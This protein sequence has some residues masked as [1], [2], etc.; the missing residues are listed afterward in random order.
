MK[1][2]NLTM[3]S[4]ACL[5]IILWGCGNT[6]APVEN[7]GNV[8]ITAEVTSSENTDPAAEST[9][10][11][12]S[13]ADE[14]TTQAGT[15]SKTEDSSATGTT[16][17]NSNIDK[18]TDNEDHDDDE[19]VLPQSAEEL[20]A[21]MS[22]REK[23]C[24]MFIV[25]PEQLTGYGCVTYA[26]STV[27]QSFMDMPVGGVILFAQNLTSQDQTAQ[28]IAD[29][30][31]YSQESCGV[32]IFTAVDEEGGTVAR[33]A[34][35][36]GTTS[37]YNMEY[38]G[39]LNDTDLAYDVGSTIGSDLSGL[40]F[41][42]DFAPVA[43]VNLN[44]G[45][46]LGSRIFSSDPYV[47]SDMTAAVVRGLQD[48]GV[49]ATLKHFPGLGAAD[50][51][52]HYDNYVHIYRTLDELR[53]AE[54]VAFSGG[55]EAGAD[56]VMVGHQKVSGVGDD[57]PADLSYTVVTTLLREELGFQGLAVTDAQQMNTIAGVY[58]SGDAAVRS[59][60]AG[61]DIILMPADLWSAVDAI[62]TAVEDGRIS[63]ER[64]DESVARILM[65][66]AE[67]GLI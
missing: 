3:L 51:N 54:F 4:A 52:T 66:K 27:R 24:Q 57:L 23:V 43:D 50:G 21:G 64:I 31:S 59:V 49:C 6:V 14:N 13:G 9:S 2:L 1:K 20:M 12:S 44:S 18:N 58:G 38:Y 56:F 22:L 45:N 62:C 11:E 29:F 25:T 65:R 39:S 34:Q 48:Q 26:D 63:E 16:G 36:L 30:Q 35:K 15:E 7:D 32:G 42:V 60:E 37:F 67:L 41:N 61:I 8:N 17:D 19:I 55:I 28:L 47:V 5:S 33:A 40:G 10:Q 46:E 53:E